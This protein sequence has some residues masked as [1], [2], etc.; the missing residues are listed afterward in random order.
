MCTARLGRCVYCTC[1]EVCVLHFKHTQMLA[2]TG[3]G[4]CSTVR[5]SEG[6]GICSGGSDRGHM[7]IH[8]LEYG[9]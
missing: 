3:A 5:T 4:Q 1:R 8:V 6:S 7:Y 9:M 2:C